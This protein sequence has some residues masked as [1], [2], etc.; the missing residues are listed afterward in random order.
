MER[1]ASTTP[2]GSSSETEFLLTWV[3]NP[4]LIGYMS[5]DKSFYQSY[6]FSRD[7]FSDTILQKQKLKKKKKK[8]FQK[9]FSLGKQ[10]LRVKSEPYHVVETKQKRKRNIYIYMY[11]HTLHTHSHPQCTSSAKNSPLYYITLL[12]EIIRVELFF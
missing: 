11:I 6:L 12:V 10:G 3:L 1:E 5:S 4:L 9:M 8:I 7:S 2:E